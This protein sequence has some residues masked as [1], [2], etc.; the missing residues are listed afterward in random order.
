MVRS[1]LY[2]RV[3]RGAA[4][5]GCFAAR[6]RR[7]QVSN[8]LVV[9]LEVR[10]T[11]RS[12]EEHPAGGKVLQ[13]LSEVSTDRIRG[14][15]LPSN[16]P[17]SP[18]CLSTTMECWSCYRRRA[19]SSHFGL[20]THCRPQ[21]HERRPRSDRPPELR[22]GLRKRATPDKCAAAKPTNG[23]RTGGSTNGNGRGARRGR[24]AGPRSRDAP[25]PGGA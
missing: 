13:K 15:A 19:R 8:L 1:P 23:S 16:R 12:V 24:T 9:H 6:S 14:P 2:C 25:E 11:R 21:R 10:A 7:D 17:T 5:T 4:A 20:L 18:V 22:P 3:G